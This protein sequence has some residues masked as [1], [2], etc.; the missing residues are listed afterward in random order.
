MLPLKQSVKN[1]IS[2][3]NIF[4]LILVLSLKSDTVFDL[5]WTYFQT[6]SD[7]VIITQFAV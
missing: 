5:W 7:V 2:D 6:V 4:T 3:G 1:L